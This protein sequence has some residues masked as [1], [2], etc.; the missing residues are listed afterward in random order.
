LLP[1][2]AIRVN[3]ITSFVAGRLSDLLQGGGERDAA[4]V[5]ESG[6]IALRRLNPCGQFSL[7]PGRQLS[8]ASPP[9]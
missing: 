9:G 7:R 4:A 8:C 1:G 2:Y 5:F 3:I 6:D